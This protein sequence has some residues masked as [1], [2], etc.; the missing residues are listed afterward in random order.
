LEHPDFAD[1][2]AR[3]AAE[4]IAFEVL[5][6]VLRSRGK[7]PKAARERLDDPGFRARMQRLFKAPTGRLTLPRLWD[8]ADRV[9]DLERQVSE[10][11]RQL[12]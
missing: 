2:A 10:L 7:T 8:L 12:G 4:E 3:H 1:K 11:Q 5:K 6:P 9:S